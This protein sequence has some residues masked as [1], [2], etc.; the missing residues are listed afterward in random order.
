MNWT[1]NA[2]ATRS[3]N[4]DPMLISIWDVSALLGMKPRKWRL[5]GWSICHL[6]IKYFFLYSRPDVPTEQM[7]CY[8][9]VPYTFNL[10]GICGSSTWPRLIDTW[11][12]HNIQSY[13]SLAGNVINVFFPTK[14][15]HLHLLTTASM[16][17]FRL[18][19]CIALNLST[20]FSLHLLIFAGERWQTDRQAQIKVGN[21]ETDGK[22]DWD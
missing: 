20:I 13:G 12:S 6:I 22:P 9:G 1:Y 8:V 10:W 7:T 18:C 4:P 3:L 11:C 17:F 19:Q 16:T 21:K 14:Y 15:Q 5:L 2:T